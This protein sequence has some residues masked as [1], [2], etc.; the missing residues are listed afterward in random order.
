MSPCSTLMRSAFIAVLR[1]LDLDDQRGV[2]AHQLERRAEG[3][4]RLR[5]E[6]HVVQDEQ[7][8]ERRP[9]PAPAAGRPAAPVVAGRPGR[10]S[11]TLASV[12]L[13]VDVTRNAAGARLVLSCRWM[14]S[15]R[16]PSPLLALSIALA[17]CGSGGGPTA[18]P[19]V[20][21]HAVGV[22][23]FYD[24]NAN[25]T[26]EPTESVR[27]PD[28][29]VEIGGKQGRSAA[30]S[31]EA[32]IESVPAGSQTLSVRA[33]SLPPFFE[34]PA[35]DDPRRAPDGRNRLPAGDAAHR[36]QSP[37]H[38]PG[39]RRQHHRRRGLERRQRLRVAAAAQAAGALRARHDHQGRPGGDA[40]QPRLRPPARQPH[41]A[42][43]VHPHPL[44]DQRL[45][46][47]AVQVQPALLHHRQPAPHGA[48]T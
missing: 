16:P 18:P 5:R 30:L 22:A 2:A 34:R 44:R 17:G 23:L 43:R 3:D 24:E 26:M 38:L 14:P 42:S 45:E 33:S 37:Q 48:A 36:G 15:R 39:L 10:S 4:H 32:I 40:Q 28:A 20:P 7:H 19:P 11:G 31:G 6:N 35:P 47:R 25:G 1:V 12:L 29:V 46:R 13:D 21:T 27:I 8:A 41:R 9:R